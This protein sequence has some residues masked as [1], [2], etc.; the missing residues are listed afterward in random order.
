MRHAE[1]AGRQNEPIDIHGLEK[2]PEKTQ[3]RQKG[4]GGVPKRTGE[5]SRQ[6]KSANGRKSGKKK[7]LNPSKAGRRQRKGEGFCHNGVLNTK[8]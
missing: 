5:G 6:K 3:K 4:T 1:I 2:R 7:L 8:F